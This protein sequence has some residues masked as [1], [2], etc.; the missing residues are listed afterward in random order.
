[1]SSDSKDITNVFIII[2]VSVI[3]ILFGIFGYLSYN[4]F[5]ES[6]IAFISLILLIYSSISLVYTLLQKKYYSNTEFNINFGMDISIILI[7]VILCIF[8]GIKSFLIKSEP[9]VY[10]PNNY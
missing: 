2:I 1:M 6:F 7:S 5:S 10:Y 4:K 9:N 3:S 8:F